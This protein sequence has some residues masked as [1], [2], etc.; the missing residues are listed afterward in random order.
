MKESRQN[1]I[2]H[3]KNKVSTKNYRIPPKYSRIVSMNHPALLLSLKTRH[4]KNLRSVLRAQDG[5]SS[6]SI[7]QPDLKTQISKYK[8]SLFDPVV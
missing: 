7:K 1:S 8:V 6:Q 2:T 5:W 4:M 3:N